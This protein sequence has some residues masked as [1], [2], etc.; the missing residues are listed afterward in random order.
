MD[1]QERGER[2]GRAEAHGNIK[3]IFVSACSG[4]PE[5]VLCEAPALQQPPSAQAL[6]LAGMEGFGGRK[7]RRC[8]T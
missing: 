2:H 4:L 5:L 3:Q 1:G 6:L 8:G 7:R